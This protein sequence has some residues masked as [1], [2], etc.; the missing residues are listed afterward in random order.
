MQ[1]KAKQSNHRL[2]L[3]FPVVDESS[4]LTWLSISAL[5]KKCKW[6]DE[7][8]ELCGMALPIP[9]LKVRHVRRGFDQRR[10]GKEKELVA[11]IDEDWTR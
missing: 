6:D 11:G 3:A 5:D 8:K 1:R 4:F 2:S 10:V 7:I 9:V